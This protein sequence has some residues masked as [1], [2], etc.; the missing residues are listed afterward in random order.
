MYAKIL[1]ICQTIYQIDNS[2]KNYKYFESGSAEESI[3]TII[4][5]AV[6]IDK[7]VIVIIYC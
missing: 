2:T 3:N 5:K 6:S 1:I 4:I 7:I